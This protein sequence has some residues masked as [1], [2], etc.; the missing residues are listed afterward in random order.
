MHS[1]QLQNC[2]INA[3]HFRYIQLTTAMF[4][5]TII[6]VSII[7][8]LFQCKHTTFIESIAS[9][10]TVLTHSI[11]AD[12]IRGTQTGDYVRIAMRDQIANCQ[13]FASV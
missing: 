8:P 12:L 5:R 4:H 9:C 1:L 11:I 3:F 2:V 13:L 6:I 10:S 7:I